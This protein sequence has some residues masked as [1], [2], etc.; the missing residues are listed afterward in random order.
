MGYR[1]RHFTKTR[2]GNY[3]ST[4]LIRS[5]VRILVILLNL[6]SRKHFDIPFPSNFSSLL[7]VQIL[8]DIF[9]EE[10]ALWEAYTLVLKEHQGDSD[11]YKSLIETIN[12]EL[13]AT[14]ERS[15]RLE[16]A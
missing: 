8:C 11:K 4:I 12:T 10:E 7:L 1:T 16:T 5:P 6:V 13:K 9:E 3:R 14:N 2:K 15:G